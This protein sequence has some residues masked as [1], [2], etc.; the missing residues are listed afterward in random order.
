MKQQLKQKSAAL[1]SVVK[2][3]PIA[4]LSPDSL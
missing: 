1:E 3:R 2:S 4:L